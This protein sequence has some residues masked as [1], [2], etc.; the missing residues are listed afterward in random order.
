VGTGIARTLGELGAAV[1][2]NDL[3]SDRAEL[4]TAQLRADGIHALAVPFDVT[5]EVEVERGTA[6]AVEAFGLPVDILVNNAGVPDG[7]ALTRFRDMD[8]TTWRRYIDL[9][10]YGSL[11]CIRNVVGGMCDR[12]WGRIVQISSGAGRTGL[13]IGISLYGASKSGIEGFV[14]HLAQEVASNGVTVNTVA[15]GLMGTE[16]PAEP[17]SALAAMVRGIPVG[18][19]G[20]PGDVGAAVG[21]LASEEA[22]WLTGQ[23]INLNGGAT[24]N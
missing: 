9:N 6:T 23:T 16:P 17:T 15:L 13:P 11:H 14:R 21:F 1:A 22:A 4:T 24:T 7:M 12:G 2:V 10:L 19:L 8:P 3:V 5:D 20:R 18:R